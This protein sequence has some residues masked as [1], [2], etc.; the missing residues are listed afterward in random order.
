MN[1]QNSQSVEQQR[2]VLESLAELNDQAYILS[3]YLHGITCEVC[4]L[5]NSNWTIITICEEGDWQILASHP[6]LHEA[7]PESSFHT[8]L[9]AILLQH[10]LLQHIDDVEHHLDHQEQLGSYTYSLG[11][12]LQTIYGRVIG[13][14][15]AFHQ[16]PCQHSSEKISIVQSL[17]ERAA[18]AI[19]N[20][21]LYQQKRLS[22]QRLEKEIATGLRELQA[23]Q[24]KLAT[25]ERLAE[26]GEFTALIIH[27][28][29]NPLTTIEMGLN[30]A[31]KRLLNTSDQKRLAL[32]LNESQRLKQ[33]LTEILLY[34]KPQV[35]KRSRLNL[36]DFLSE[37]LIQ[38]KDMP[39]AT[40]RQIELTFTQPDIHISADRDKLKQV[41]IN[42][43]RNAFE[44]ISPGEKIRC[45]I[46]SLHS[47]R[48]CIH[49]HNNGEPIPP[50]ILPHLTTPFCSTKPS[51][52]G[53]GLAIVKRIITAH[54]GELTI[55]SSAAGTTV[56]VQLSIV[57]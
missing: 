13:T 9:S 33:L 2:Y 56:S 32:A 17:A 44:A 15:Y 52:T 10:G 6:L 24:S 29:R 27:E 55:H 3:R 35:L 57:P 25:Q 49:I 26:I 18:M 43:V 42:L 5:L 46:S 31:K 11:V 4:Q 30:Y 38:L 20:Y 34:T 39:E 16:H 41:F 12:P 47:E 19:E 8:E 28:I 21:Q 53:L 7:G 22:D 45:E 14:L 37:L 50:E 1:L 51:G 36:G 54:D 23:I 40:D 48:V